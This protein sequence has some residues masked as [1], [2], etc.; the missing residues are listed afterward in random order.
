MDQGVEVIS[1]VSPAGWLD[2]QCS[3]SHH[4]ALNQEL[5]GGNAE[6]KGKRE[7]DTGSTW[8]KSYSRWDKVGAST[9]FIQSSNFLI[10]SRSYLF[11]NLFK[12]D[13]TFILV[14]QFVTII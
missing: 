12:K 6:M 9:G 11:L 10:I 1:A 14:D 2:A 5:E 3:Y 8:E 13:K 7:Q 4:G